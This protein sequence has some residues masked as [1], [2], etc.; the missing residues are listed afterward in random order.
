VWPAN[1]NNNT[2]AQQGRNEGSA[3]EEEEDI[4]SEGDVID[5]KYKIVKRLGKGGYGKY[6]NIVNIRAI[7]SIF[8]S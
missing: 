1:I 8:C 3:A 2:M 7:L 5:E 6:H 4:F